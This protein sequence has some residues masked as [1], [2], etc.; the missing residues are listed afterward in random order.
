M[1]T[2]DQPATKSDIARLGAEI[3][4]GFA[5]LDVKSATKADTGRLDAKIDRV[6]VEVVH[7]QADIR[8]I[9]ATMSTKDDFERI[10]RHIDKFAADAIHYHRAD[11]TRGKALIDVEVQVTDHE[12]R[13]SRLE[14]SRGPT[15]PGA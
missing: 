6:A 11:A 13:I 9:K 7:A 15:A 12:R 1:D 10:M 4:E 5:A 14:G 8:D 2:K 3:K